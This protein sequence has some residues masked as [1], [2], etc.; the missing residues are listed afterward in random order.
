MSHL[1]VSSGATQN[2]VLYRLLEAD[3]VLERSV[4]GGRTWIRAQLHFQGRDNQQKFDR[5]R[6][7]TTIV[8]TNGLTLYG[9]VYRRPGVRDLS[10]PQVALWRGVYVSHD[11]GDDWHLFASDLVIGTTVAEHG[12]A[13]FAVSASGLVESKDDGRTWSA[14]QIAQHLPRSFPITGAEKAPPDRRGEPLAVY[15]MEF[16]PNDSHAV[17]LVT[18]GGLFIS[19]DEG[20]N[21]CLTTFGSD[22]FDMVSSVALANQSG[23]HVFATTVDRSGPALWESRNGGLSFQRVSIG[24]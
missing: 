18:N 19:H 2:K 15:Q 23:S 6:M 20:Q 24:E 7:R 16:S 22:T 3:S 10:A 17:F 8:G 1:I 13:V 4:D 12:S 21:W 9:R 14:A 11:G 5:K